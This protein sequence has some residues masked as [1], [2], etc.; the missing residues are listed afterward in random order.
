MRLI[1]SKRPGR[2]SNFSRHW[3]TA[4]CNGCVDSFCQFQ[5]CVGFIFM[6]GIGP[7]HMGKFQALALHASSHHIGGLLLFVYFAAVSDDRAV[8]EVASVIDSIVE[9]PKRLF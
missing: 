3:V 1:V 9:M 8:E 7:D 6:R 4:F 5:L 2:E